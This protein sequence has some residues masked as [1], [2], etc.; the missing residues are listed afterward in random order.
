MIEIFI[1]TDVLIDLLAERT[2]YYND[3]AIIFSL[4]DNGLIKIYI[5]SLCFSNI[6][7]IISKLKS[8]NESIKALRK[9]RILVNVLNVNANTIDSALNSDFKDFEDAIQ[10]FT[11]LQNQVSMIITRNTKDYNVSQLPVKT[12]AEFIKFLKA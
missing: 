9:L 5:S 8:K 3:A 4:A 12:P 10:Y 2:P 1:D 7:Y 11:P 6:H